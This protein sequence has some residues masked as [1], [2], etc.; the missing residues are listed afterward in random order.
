MSRSFEL[1][2]APVAFKAI[3]GEAQR[4][5]RAACRLRN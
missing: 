2:S 1:G 4:L 5:V 3:P